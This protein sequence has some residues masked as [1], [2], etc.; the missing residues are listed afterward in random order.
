MALVN[1]VWRESEFDPPGSEPGLTYRRDYFEN[2]QNMA[3]Q[4]IAHAR[5]PYPTEAYP[6]FKTF[7]NRPEHTIGVRIGAGDLLFP[8][9]VVMNSATTEVQMLAEVETVRS[10]READLVEKWQAFSAVG[11]LYIYVPLSQL[12]RTRRALRGSGVRV[13]GLRTW[14]INMGQGTVDVVELAG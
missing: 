3:V 8:D 2:V 11:K 4:Q 14:K 13:A 9:I 10:L 1:R 6:L 5:F 7:L 12:D